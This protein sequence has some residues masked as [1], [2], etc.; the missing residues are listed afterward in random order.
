[1]TVTTPL[2]GELIFEHNRV[3]K[4]FHYWKEF[5]SGIITILKKTTILITFKTI[6]FHLTQM[7]SP[8]EI[9]NKM[10]LSVHLWRQSILRVS[11][12]L[13]WSQKEYC[14]IWNWVL[15]LKSNHYSIYVS[16]N[17]NIKPFLNLCFYQITKCL[18]YVYTSMKSLI[19]IY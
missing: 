5:I 8:N 12:L 3:S 4:M 2:Y 13:E 11:C 18:N 1:M 6:K 16:T 14:V 15:E 7:L 19:T 17:F 9:T 10:K